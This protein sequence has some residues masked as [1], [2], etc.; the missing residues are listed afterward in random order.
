MLAIQK[1][2]DL[3]FIH[4]TL[5]KEKDIDKII[6]ELVL[7]A[8][9]EAKNV[10]SL[11]ELEGDC[12]QEDNSDLRILKK[13]P[14]NHVFNIIKKENYTQTGKDELPEFYKGIVAK[15]VEQHPGEA[16]V[17]HP[18]CIA[19][20]AMRDIIASK[21]GT[22]TRQI[23]CRSTTTGKI[24]VAKNGLSTAKLTEDQARSK[25]EGY[26]CLYIQKNI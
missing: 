4:T 5:Q 11:K 24:V 10:V 18:L 26:A 2:C 7:K 13:C 22:F 8:N 16:A 20:Q 17:L 21:K 14:M 12:I 23:A 19:H 6:E 3:E 1:I 15:F 25:L 9:E